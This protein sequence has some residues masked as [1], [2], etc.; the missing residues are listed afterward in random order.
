MAHSAHGIRTFLNQDGTVTI[1]PPNVPY[2][3]VKG[4]QQL[5]QVREI[6]VHFP[7]DDIV[8]ADITA[9]VSLPTIIHASPKFHCYTVKDGKQIPLFLKYGKPSFIQRLLNNLKNII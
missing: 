4:T 1:V 9:Y 8:T 5:R 3:P 6:T 2:T 7:C